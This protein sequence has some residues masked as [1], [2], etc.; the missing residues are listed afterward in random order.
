MGAVLVTGVSGLLGNRVASTLAARNVTVYGAYGA[1]RE[2]IWAP[3]ADARAGVLERSEELKAW[4]EQTGMRAI[5]HCAAMTDVNAC[6]RDHAAAH[7]AN[8]GVTRSLAQVAM[9]RR[10]RLLYL[11][12]STVF[13]GNEGNY[14]EDDVPGP[15]NY[16][17]WTKL[18]GEES[19]RM[20]P[21]ACVVRATVI[22]RHPS[23]PASNFMEWLVE[24]FESGGEMTLFEDQ[25]IN[26]VSDLTLAEVLCDLLGRGALPPVLHVGTRDTCSKADVGRWLAKHAFPDHRCRIRFAGVD[27]TRGPDD[28]PRPKEM[29]LNVDRVQQLPIAM[30]TVEDELRRV[31]DDNR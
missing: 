6:E 4:I 13:S 17:S 18:L 20:V 25:R 22:G 24:Q 3:V 8:V 30:P 12:T 2:R 15:A 9:E 16:Y 11:S 28:A 14:R 10:L 27:D 19:V 1:R 26:A 21:G 5:V 31:M 23:R 7:R 29:W